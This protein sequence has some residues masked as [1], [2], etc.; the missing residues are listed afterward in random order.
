M[1]DL[2]PTLARHPSID[3]WL[4]VGDGYVTIRTGK[5]EIGQGIKTALIAIA[6]EELDLRPEQIR[7][8]TAHTGRTPNE[9]IT[10]GS[11]SIEDSGMALR[12]MAAAARAHM[13]ARAAAEL[14]VAQSEL[15][16]V[17][18]AIGGPGANRT[19]SYFDLQRGQPFDTR[20]DA[21]PATKPAHQYRVV[22]LP[23]RRVDLPA[24]VFGEAAFVH[25]LVL[26]GMLHARVLRPPTVEAR[27]ARASLDG[28]A[29]DGL[30][31]TVV[32]GSF[33]AI[34]A[35]RE[36]Q[37]VRAATRLAT[38]LTW[39]APPIAPSAAAL[40]DHLDAH[41][42][43]RLLVV[44]G[45]PVDE[46]VPA[47]LTGADV[48]SA[49]YSRP[50]QM[51][52]SIGPSAAVA[53]YAN[54]RLTVWTH[55][56][57]PEILRIALSTVVALPIEQIEVVH[58]EGS[59]CY[60]HNGA[61]DAAAD[62]ALVALAVPG[63][64]ISLKW[65]RADEHRFEPYAPPMRITLRAKLNG[66]RIAAWDQEIVS[67]PHV[68]RS[69]APVP[70][71][72]N[73]L[74]AWH[75]DPPQPR[76]PA[77]PGR[78]P[79]GGIHRNGDPLYRFAS[80]RIVKCFVPEGPLRASS[81]RGLGALANVFAIESFIDELAARCR[82]DPFEFRLRHLEDGR[83][84]AV[85]ERLRAMLPARTSTPHRGRGIAFAQYKN[86]QTYCAIAVD[87]R[88]DDAPVAIRLEHAY[89]AADAGQAIDPDGVVNQLEGGFVQAAS[90]TLKEEVRYDASGVQ[91]VD[92]ATYPI[93]AF[94][95][96]PDVTTALID[97]PESPPLGAG[98]ASV[99]PAAAA[100]ANAIADAVGARL[101]DLPL[102]AEKLVAALS[103]V[104]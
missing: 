84:R 61:D 64:P 37:A 65:T 23:Q 104:A 98:E 10:A 71:R 33:V 99:G 66:D 73:L 24:K 59:G 43:A 58:A 89:I 57:G 27:L 39:S 8:E 22:G 85:L 54:D 9:F 26:D 67:L 5:V 18:G 12:A 30:V 31:A 3:E 20:L 52:A 75:L 13:V 47:P 34:V 86:A 41:V 6:A 35:E 29:A 60:G 62:A 93:L 46:P 74:A 76:I 82:A 40:H 92:W 69:V 36:E 68:S 79:H 102:T 25:D 16:V 88:I 15:T 87:L 81:T 96:V 91:S 14:G 78:M 100:I 50:Y 28:F 80:K 21:L 101:R 19:I 38:R 2:P 51:H 4:A 42:S 44:D 11:R 77:R 83:A 7:I 45:T 53:R 32:R 94:D 72:S 17:E 95:E 90:W 97:R 1:A 63:R 48:V 70:G 49:R 55:S 103:T 56:Q